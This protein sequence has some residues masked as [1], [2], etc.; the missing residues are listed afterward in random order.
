[1]SAANQVVAKQYEKWQAADAAAHE[2]WEKVDQELRRLIRLAKIGRKTVIVI[3]I[4][5]LRGVEIRNQFKG[6]IKVFAPAFAKKWK[7]REISLESE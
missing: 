3:P 4:S 2:Q 1:M 5:E 6:E 7:V